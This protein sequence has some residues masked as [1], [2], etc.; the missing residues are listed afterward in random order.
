MKFR[1]NI[2]N[3]KK[4]LIVV[5]TNDYHYGRLLNVI[6]LGK[7]NYV[8]DIYIFSQNKSVYYSAREFEII[9][10]G[11]INRILKDFAIRTIISFLKPA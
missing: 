3:P 1:K 9:Y 11:D 6:H 5:H 10:K 7:R 4:D 8:Y 2:L